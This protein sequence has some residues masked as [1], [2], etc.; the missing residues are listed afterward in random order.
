MSE[1]NTEQENVQT[2]GVTLFHLFF[3]IVFFS[4]VFAVVT[5][6]KHA[7]GGVLRYVLAIPIAIVFGALVVWLNWICGRWSWTKTKHSSNR[8]Q[9]IIATISFCLLLISIVIE[10][11]SVFK[12]VPLLIRFVA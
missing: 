1:Q 3:G 4:P 11:I 7:G 6:I 5:E 2:G 10:D 9:G 8:I 12:L